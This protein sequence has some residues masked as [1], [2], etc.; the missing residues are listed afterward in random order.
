VAASPTACVLGVR[1]RQ[2]DGMTLAEPPPAADTSPPGRLNGPPPTPRRR[3]R[4]WRGLSMGTWLAIALLV[5]TVLSLLASA[6]AT[7]VQASD[8]AER[9]A[10][11][12]SA[13]L[14]SLQ[15]DEI[16]RY[17]AAMQGHAV[18]LA[19]S[20]TV[21]AALDRFTSA[22]DELDDEI[23]PGDVSDATTDLTAY[24]REALIPGLEA[25]AGQDV[26]V[27]RLL[28]TSDAGRYLQ[29]DYTVPD[30]DADV[31]VDQR[32]DAG[33]GSTWS[34]VHADLHTTLARMADLAGFEDLLLVSADPTA[35]VYT[36]AKLPD[37]GTSL[38]VGP[39][40]G[41][42]MGGA[43]RELR[44]ATELD[45]GPQLTDIASY[46]A[47]A[48]R[49]AMF[50]VAPVTD[51]DELLGL[52]VG[53]LPLDQI[54]RIM[55]A[56]GAWE[57][58]GF[59][60]TGETFL[61]GA[62][63]RMRSV[64]RPFV[65]DPDAYLRQVARARTATPG[66]RRAMRATDT[67]V[68]VQRVFPGDEVASLP[69]A[70]APLRAVGYLGRE[71][72][73]G[74]E[75]L[76]VA[77]LDWVVVVQAAAT[78]VDADLISYRRNTLV[79]VAVVILIVAMGAVAWG[80]RTFRPVQAVSDRHRN[81][82]GR[83]G[84]PAVAG[85]R[86]PREFADLTHSVEDMVDALARD[87]AEVDAATA[88]RRA[89]LDALLPPAVAARL[90]DG[91][92]RIVDQIHQASVVV[93]TIAG[94]GRIVQRG[95]VQAGRETLDAIVG[96]LDPLAERH[97]LVRVKLLG[98]SYFAGCGLERPFLD[99]AVRAVRFARDARRE[100]QRL[101]A[102]AVDDVRLAIGID[103]GPVTVGLTGSALLVFEMWGD[104]VNAAH[105]LAQQARPG[106]TLLSGR[107]R[108]LLPDDV[109]VHRRE[110]AAG[111]VWRLEEVAGSDA[112]EP[113]P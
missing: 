2:L 56:G 29:A 110:G 94:L 33:D 65:E 90:A 39:Y 86:T 13:A 22:F 52:L 75:Q 10:A 99:H 76:D 70:S 63:G 68:P 32:T 108:A 104:T 7:L 51:G 53:R 6:L 12:R 112:E 36:V 66:E 103:S 34:A 16:E 48:G 25:V 37:L 43:V 74:V 19:N 61:V 78:Q 14:L 46:G 87:R 47:T 84:A 58:A 95:D 111:V 44:D 83:P 54:D 18:V 41:S 106:T 79:A 91:D 81:H 88:E 80:R 15:A 60:A 93:L 64:S 31:P 23:A 11:A 89:T 69:A 24:Y 97:G 20:D 9:L 59:G 77:G 5:V 3:R 102:D 4:P 40:S 109:I 96:T 45:P 57:D 30:P 92:R 98:D 71:V 49:P 107:A 42:A 113:Q 105:L 38:E 1:T 28:P 62:D 35:V 8:Q 82:E 100:V 55:T 26:A 85:R 101:T 50:V 67:T 17:L 27:D 72:A 21:V 73:T